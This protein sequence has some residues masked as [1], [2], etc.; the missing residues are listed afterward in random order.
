MA[1]TTVST[2]IMM[3]R[4]QASRR[5]TTTTTRMTTRCGAMRLRSLGGGRAVLQATQS[6]QQP[7]QR[8][9]RQPDPAAVLAPALALACLVGGQAQLSPQRRLEAPSPAGDPPLP[10][11]L[12][13][14]A[15]VA[16]QGWGLRCSGR[17]SAARSRLDQC[18][19]LSDWPAPAALPRCRVPYRRRA[20]AARCPTMRLQCWVP[21]CSSGRW[22]RCPSEAS[23]RRLPARLAQPPLVLQRVGL[24]LVVTGRCPPRA[25]L[26]QAP[27]ALVLLP[28]LHLH[29]L[30]VLMDCSTH[31]AWP[32]TCSRTP[33]AAAGTRAAA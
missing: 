17:L 21:R 25:S 18:L 1:R 2:L 8:Q 23:L 10:L 28:L 5:T 30:Q 33:A 31:R 14:T 24:G 29:P 4:A 32:P 20:A 13:A 22:M 12:P 9:R 11:P 16:A 15:Q 6:P 3:T 19:T 7:Q 27:G 26:A